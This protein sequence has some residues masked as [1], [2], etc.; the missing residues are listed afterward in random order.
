MVNC[1]KI[2]LEH[3]NNVY[4]PIWEK[5]MFQI[6]FER[7]HIDWSPIIVIFSIHSLVL[8]TFILNTRFIVCCFMP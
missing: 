8:S 6:L 2:S 1:I 7:S 3:T 5:Q 4:S